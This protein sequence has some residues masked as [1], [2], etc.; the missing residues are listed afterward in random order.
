MH[1]D[2]NELSYILL[3]TNPT[4][5]FSMPIHAWYPHKDVTRVR[6][7]FAANRVVVTGHDFKALSPRHEL[8]KVAVVIERINI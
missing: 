3:F 7:G 2:W 4:R 5:T 1:F 6:Y 8:V